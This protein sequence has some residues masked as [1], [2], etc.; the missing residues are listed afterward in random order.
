MILREKWETLKQEME[1]LHIDEKDLEETYTLGSGRGG[2][3]IQKTHSLVH[4]KH[5]PTGLMVSC[6]KTRSR[7]DNRFFA[8]RALLEKV[9]IARGLPTKQSKA[10]DKIRKAK[11]RRERR[12]RQSEI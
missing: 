11:K 4:L 12:R 3:K 2:Q 10:H 5:L 1:S 8:R 7:E 6:Q 9:R